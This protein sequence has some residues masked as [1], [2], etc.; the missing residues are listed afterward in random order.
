MKINMLWLFILPTV[1]LS[2]FCADYSGILRGSQDIVWTNA[3]YNNTTKSLVPTV[4]SLANERTTSEWY[5]GTF[6]NSTYHT[7]TFRDFLGHE[8]ETKVEY[9]SM[10]YNLGSSL[11]YFNK[12]DVNDNPSSGLYPICSTFSNSL[13]HRDGGC[14][15]SYGFISDIRVEPFKFYRPG[16]N[17]PN[18]AEKFRE[19]PSGRYVANLFLT[20]FYLYRSDSGVLSRR[21]MSE[22]IILSIDY[23]SA[24]LDSVTIISGDGFMEPNYDKSNK[25]VNGE[26]YY[27][28]E[29]RGRLPTGAIMRFVDFENDFYMSSQLDSA[30]KLPY[31]FSCVLGCNDNTSQEIISNGKF[32]RS[33][34]PNGEVLISPSGGNTSSIL[35]KYRIYYEAAES[36]VITSSYNDSINIIYEVNI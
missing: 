20:P 32:N 12:L 24:E 18:L 9:K 27:E 25:K 8:F 10:E 11:G 7:V 28:V 16:I 4:W 36:E 3:V 6:L 5:P 30:A 15:G 1:S 29:L 14:I 19:L 34:F 22:P 31:S 17:L 33:Q 23:I 13:A 35:N 2:A 26:A 21:Q